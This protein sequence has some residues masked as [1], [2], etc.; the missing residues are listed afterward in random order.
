MRPFHRSSPPKSH[1]LA[2]RFAIRIDTKLV[3]ELADELEVNLPKYNGIPFLLNH[4]TNK[5][6]AQ[7]GERALDLWDQLPAEER[8]E[9][10]NK[11][12]ACCV[13]SAK[14]QL[15]RK[16]YGLAYRASE[17]YES[18]SFK[19]LTTNN[20]IMNL[21]SQIGNL[22]RVLEIYNTIPEPDSISNST[23]L[24]A[25]A[26]LG[27]F[28]DAEQVWLENRDS[29]YAY[30]NM[31]LAYERHRPDQISL[32]YRIWE[33]DANKS[34]LIPKPDIQSSNIVLRA[35]S[36]ASHT[37]VEAFFR[38]MKR[39]NSVSYTSYVAAVCSTTGNRQVIMDAVEQCSDAFD[40]PTLS[41]IVYSLAKVPSMASFC[42]ST[43]R[44]SNVRMTLE[45]Y[46]ALIYAWFRETRSN[47]E[48]AWRAM[49][50]YAEIV[51]DTALEPN[52]KTYTNVVSALKG[53]GDGA[54][55]KAVEVVANMEASTTRGNIH[56]YT[57]LIQCYSLSS[58]PHKAREAWN[59][60]QRLDSLGLQ[61]NIVTYNS[62]INAC[63]HTRSSDDF[64]VAEEA[65]HIAT[66]VL[67]EI[68]LASLANHVTYGSFLGVLVNHMPESETRDKLLQL[69]FQKIVHEG[70]L[71]RLVLKGLEGAAPQT[72]KLLL[73]G[74]DVDNLPEEWTRNVKDVKARYIA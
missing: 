13:V 24:H 20:T 15:P 41:N 62:V 28:Q 53:R 26:R 29:I 69:I 3:Q 39:Y 61:P 51:Q 49:D 63:E 25:I 19:D 30:N 60:L 22:E 12:L 42:E 33:K 52:V 5:R 74:Y 56:V 40:A 35:F 17:A 2:P 31:L 73:Q 47:T 54:L 70:Q 34:N 50:L 8:M 36:K 46:N 37:E 44:S 14:K 59:V 23:L 66:K 72:W 38:S 6:P 67:E 64:S 55:E 4:L 65:L 57:A 27:S 71:S 7:A 45:L 32:F 68:R 11:V 10:I 1:I 21:W 43:V 9:H 16:N 18:I 58:H 48:A